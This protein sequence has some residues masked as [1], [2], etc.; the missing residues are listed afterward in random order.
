[1]INLHSKCPVV[2]QCLIAI[3]MITSADVLTVINANS[4]SHML[5]EVC[6]MD[7]LLKI[8]STLG[9][10]TIMVMMAFNTHLGV[11]RKKQ[12]CFIL[13]KLMEF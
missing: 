6:T 11:L 7:L 13:N 8:K 5:K 4:T 10:I 12:T 1:M 9:K 3:Q 2:A